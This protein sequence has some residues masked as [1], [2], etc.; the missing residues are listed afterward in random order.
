MVTSFLVFNAKYQ[1]HTDCTNAP[2]QWFF[3]QKW[4]IVSERNLLI[5]NNSVWNREFAKPLPP[6]ARTKIHMNAKQKTGDHRSVRRGQVELSTRALG[7][8]VTR[9]HQVWKSL[10]QFIPI[11][12]QPC[13]NRPELAERHLVLSLV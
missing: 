3:A 5:P 1:L 13:P 9:S 12:C 4:G 2:K 7:L 11:G 8:R 10:S 6:L